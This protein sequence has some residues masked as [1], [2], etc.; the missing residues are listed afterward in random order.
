M[1]LSSNYFIMWEEKDCGVKLAQIYNKSFAL[2]N[3]QLH[4]LAQ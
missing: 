2:D 1:D 3:G 4:R